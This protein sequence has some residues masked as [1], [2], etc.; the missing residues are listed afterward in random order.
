MIS[1]VNADKTNT[2]T[3]TVWHFIIA[4]VACRGFSKSARSVL[5]FNLTQTHTLAHSLAQR[6][7]KKI[8]F[9]SSLPRLDYVSSKPFA[10]IYNSLVILKKVWNFEIPNCSPLGRI[11]IQQWHYYKNHSTITNNNLQV[12]R[13]SNYAELLLGTQSTEDAISVAQISM[14]SGN[15][16]TSSH[17]TGAY[18]FPELMLEG[19]NCDH[20]GKRW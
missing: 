20:T 3:E 8:S 7:A 17:H 2:L 19:Y 4:V 14:R 11:H 1:N 15:L 18:I 13:Q 9:R 5:T 6:T 12:R 10:E 16:I